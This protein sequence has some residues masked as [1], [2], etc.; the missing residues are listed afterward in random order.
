MRI[1]I[2]FISIILECSIYGMK[3]IITTEKREGH[4]TTINSKQGNESYKKKFDVTLSKNNSLH[5]GE[6]VLNN[7]GLYFAYT[8]WEEVDQEKLFTVKI[9]KRKSLSP[10]KYGNDINDPFTQGN[11]KDFK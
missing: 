4:I 3:P 2:F 11:N 9:S 10:L 8:S 6:P 7:T 1:Y 5:R